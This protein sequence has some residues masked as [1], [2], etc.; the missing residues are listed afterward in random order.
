[1]EKF[2]F[3]VYGNNTAAMVT[4]IELSK[5]NSVAIINPFKSWGGHFSG[6]KIDNLN[7][8][9]GMNFFEFTS[10]HNKSNDI[11]TYC[12]NKRNDSARFFDL[13]KEYIFNYIDLCE[14]NKLESY[15]ENIFSDDI[16]IANNLKI[17][18]ELPDNIKKNIHHELIEI[19]K[20]KS[21]LHASNKKNNELLFST[22][23]LYEV[24]IANHGETFHE[25]FIEPLCNKILNLKS[26]EIPALLHRIAWAPLFYPET[27][28]SQLK[29]ETNENLNTKFHFPKSGSFSDIISKWKEKIISNPNISI[30]NDQLI[31]IDNVSKCEVE[32]TNNVILNCKKI[33]W[34]SDLKH[35]L[36]VK[37]IQNDIQLEKA[38]IIVLFFNIENKNLLRLF[39]VLNVFPFETAIYRIT[40]LDYSASVDTKTSRI[41]IE[42]NK[43][44]AES[45]SLINENEILEHVNEFL[46]NKITN[47]NINELEF[48]MKFFNNAVITP[49]NH[50]INSFNEM[51]KLANLNNENI[52]LI[53]ASANIATSSFN[54][55]L[56]H[57]LYIK[58]KYQIK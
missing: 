58:N 8:D 52:E 51:I 36:D 33:I 10:F 29:G 17:L 26:T 39:S 27:L 49:T 55:Q 23:S 13:V 9:I 2:D 7:Y 11:S 47:L 43:D 44:Y 38:S 24:S 30:I 50:N 18:T 41:V 5:N 46:F 22:K 31:R 42:I 32:L 54:D 1:M 6:L 34:C 25:I 21:E 19:L 35:F 15:T 16:A 12:F 48:E 45:L 4:A 20:N 57:G 56:I 3:I 14:V 53:G 28:L 37:K 40:N